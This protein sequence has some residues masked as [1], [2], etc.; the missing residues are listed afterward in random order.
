MRLPGSPLTK[1]PVLTKHPRAERAASAPILTAQVSQ[2]LNRL[3]IPQFLQR[4]RVV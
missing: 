1:P 3:S 4:D 2:L